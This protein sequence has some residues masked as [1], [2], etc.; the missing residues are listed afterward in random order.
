[1]LRA[2]VVQGSQQVWVAALWYWGNSLDGLSQDYLPPWWIV[3]I[4]WPLALMSFVFAYLMLYGLP[5]EGSR[6]TGARIA[7]LTIF[8]QSIIGN[9]LRKSQIS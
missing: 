5:G 6:N 4:I 7:V 8:F 9:H 3:L 2:V 1:M